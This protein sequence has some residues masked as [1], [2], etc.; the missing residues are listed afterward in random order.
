VVLAALIVAA[1]L[2]LAL[3]ASVYYAARH[4][5]EGMA[6]GVVDPHGRRLTT[7]AQDYAILALL[8]AGFWFPFVGWIALAVHLW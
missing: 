6:R 3:A 1:P 5:L 8:L 4:D 2:A 7:D